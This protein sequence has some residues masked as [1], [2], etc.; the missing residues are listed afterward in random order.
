MDEYRMT[1][2]REYCGWSRE[3]DSI[4]WKKGRYVVVGTSLTITSRYYLV[5]SND[6]MYDLGVTGNFFKALDK[7]NFIIDKL[8]NPARILANFYYEVV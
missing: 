7:A 6:F 1:T 3:N 8:K 5:L 2:N 4:L